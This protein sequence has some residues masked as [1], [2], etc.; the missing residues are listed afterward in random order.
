MSSGIKKHTTK[1]VKKEDGCFASKNIKHNPD[2]ESARA[3]FGLK[4]D[5][6]NKR[7]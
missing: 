4:D 1:N 5:K 6:D 2:E 7:G 3:V